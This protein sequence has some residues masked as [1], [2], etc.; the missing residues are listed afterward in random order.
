VQLLFPRVSAGDPA[1]QVY[2]RV[3]GLVESIWEFRVIDGIVQDYKR[4]VYDQPHHS[5]PPLAQA[6]SNYQERWYR[7]VSEDQG[8]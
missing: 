3:N 5:M 7:V 6:L 1:Y 2:L 4:W 8:R